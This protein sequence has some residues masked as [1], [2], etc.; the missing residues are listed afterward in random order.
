MSLTP[1]MEGIT[2]EHNFLIQSFMGFAWFIYPACMIVCTVLLQQLE[3]GHKGIFKN[4]GTAAFPFCFGP[5]QMDRTPCTGVFPVRTDDRTLF[6]LRHGCFPVLKCLSDDRYIHRSYAGRRYFSI[7]PAWRW[8]FTD[9]S[10]CL[11]TP[12]FLLPQGLPPWY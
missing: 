11:Q 6:Y 8:L 7:V 1:V 9:V 2:P 3:R 12:G 5:L 4:A 10:V